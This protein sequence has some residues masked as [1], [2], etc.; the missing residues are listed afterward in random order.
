MAPNFFA[1]FAFLTWSQEIVL[2]E[3]ILLTKMEGKGDDGCATVA[4]IPYTLQRLAAW[5]Y[6]RKPE[7]QETPY[8]NVTPHRLHKFKSPGIS[9]HAYS[10]KADTHQV[11]LSWQSHHSPLTSLTYLHL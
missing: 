4:L 1:F 11:T 8:S 5:C 2:A 3:L 7:A 9:S 10:L 6:F